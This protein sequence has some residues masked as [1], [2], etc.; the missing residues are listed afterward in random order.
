MQAAAGEGPDGQQAADQ[1]LEIN[2][3]QGVLRINTRL[4]GTVTVKP[5]NSAAAQTTPRTPGRPPRTHPEGTRPR[6][7]G[8]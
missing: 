6:T 7:H 2:E 4:D 1:D 5:E 8:R 3:L